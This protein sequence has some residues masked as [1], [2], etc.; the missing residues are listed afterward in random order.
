MTSKPTMRFR[1]T[2]RNVRSYWRCRNNF[3][4]TYRHRPITSFGTEC[5]EVA[6]LLE[7]LG[8]VRVWL[9]RTNWWPRLIVEDLENAEM[10]TFSTMDLLDL[11]YCRSTVRNGDNS[12]GGCP[13][14]QPD[15]RTV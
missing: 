14:E 6:I 10:V 2:L 8:G 7:P 5:R 1:E 13:T 4:P 15:G 12:E 11:V 3:S 9:D